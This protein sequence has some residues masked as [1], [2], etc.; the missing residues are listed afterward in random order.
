MNRARIL[1]KTR[2]G[3]AYALILYAVLVPIAAMWLVPVGLYPMDDRRFADPRFSFI[4]VAADD[5]FNLPIAVNEGGDFTDVV[6]FFPGNVG[7]RSLF[8][9]AVEPHIR[10]GR[11]VI[12]S[13]YRS[14]EALGGRADEALFK[15]DALAVHDAVKAR[16]PN[17]SIHL[18]GYSMGT[19][20]ALHVAARRDV[21]SVLLLAPFDK[22]CALMARIVP[23][24]HCLNPF[25]DRWRS[26]HDAPFVEAR[27]FVLHG[28]SDQIIP[29]KRSEPL[30]HLIQNAERRII[31]GADHGTIISAQAVGSARQKLR[32]AN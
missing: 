22:A 30:T 10:E 11:T 8:V 7:A 4:L 31:A 32:A 23:Y 6:I 24:P 29:P 19:G 21:A 3:V 2:R 25:I 1:S 17:A 27:T 13:P 5:G 20:L 12:L 18:E 14:A 28:G 26:V 15:S 9:P 16:Y